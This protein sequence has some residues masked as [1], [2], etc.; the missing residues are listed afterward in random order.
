MQL[1]EVFQD[2]NQ[3]DLDTITGAPGLLIFLPMLYVAWSDSVLTSEEIVSIEKRIKEQAWLSEAE[4]QFIC[5]RLDPK[6]PPTPMQLKDWLHLIQSAA[7]LIQGSSRQSLAQLGVQMAEV[8]EQS[9]DR[10]GT[11]AAQSALGD[12]EEALG[13]ITSEAY[14]S[15]L[16]EEQRPKEP[17]VE[18]TQESSFD[19]VGLQAILDGDN[20]AVR[21]KIKEILGRPEFKYQKHN[22]KEAYREQVLEWCQILANEGIGALSYPKAYG[23]A[24]AMG[25]YFAAMETMSFHDLSTV[26]KYGVQ[27]GLFGGS[28]LALGT[29]KH[30][31]KY[32]REVGLLNLPGGF[33]MTESGH[34]SNVRDIETTAIYDKEKKIFVIN[35]P[36]DNAHKEYIGNAA[37]HGRMM[38]VFAQMEI[39]E[40]NYGVSAFLVPVRDEQGQRLPGIRIE[41][42]GYKL[43][44]NGVDNGRIWFDNV[45]IPRENLLDRF[46][47]VDEQG[48]YSS[49]IAGASKRFFTMLSTLVGGRIG[50]P[51]S[52]LS[53]AKSGLTIAIKYATRRR[54]FGPPGKDEQLIM[55]YQSHQKRLMPLLAK[56]YALDFALKYLT[57][58][59]LNRTEEE[60]REVEALAAGLKSY[61]TWHTTHTLQI[62]REACGGNG[63]LSINRLDALK[64]DTEIFTTFEGD[65]TVLMQ[66]VAKSRLADFKQEFHDIK[67]FGLVK[68]IAKQATTVVTEMNPIITRKTSEDHLLDREFQLNAF[69][70]RE[71]HLV[72]R[73]GQR[74]KHRIDQ[75]MDSYQAFMEC[76]NHLIAL[77][78]AYIDRVILESF[79]QAIGEV[80]DESIKNMLNQL[81]HLFALERMQEH[82]GW[83]LENGYF[84]G[85]KSKAIRKLVTK[86]CL[87]IRQEAVP[88]VQSFGIPDHC[89]AA[90]IAL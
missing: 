75:G 5:T 65:N 31:Q 68:Y 27:F 6:H 84:E 82:A 47:S 16:T 60:A 77:A 18:A 17:V 63:Y 48:V 89:L 73:A 32:L 14:Q 12:I 90:P 24:D 66:L 43:G 41:D 38:T 11:K 26:I 55:D 28:I 79:I 76:Q 22:T 69:Q 49:P 3:A 61:S 71:R 37:Q 52:G 20:V 78:F 86:L 51:R 85:A 2:L 19:I 30:H 15:M 45:E 50:I 4:K 64:A 1:K 56:T 42:C 10:W 80:E 87:E 13:V 72:T 59:Y 83:Y 23:G 46:A 36:S 25:D 62:C 81:C 44:L 88:L 67:F 35:T 57:K 7:P 54:Q 58:R 34:G 9:Q 53:A 74:L 29:E 8:S 39:D 40:E 21:N 33:A 70:Y